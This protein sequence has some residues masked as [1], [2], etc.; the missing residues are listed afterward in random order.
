[1]LLMEQ[2]AA[3]DET[4]LACA[5]DFLVCSYK[6]LSKTKKQEQLFGIVF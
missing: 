2:L 5:F 3:A 1:M 4:K 6:T